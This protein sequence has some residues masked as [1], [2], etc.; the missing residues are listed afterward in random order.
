MKPG[1]LLKLHFTADV[2]TSEWQRLCGGSM[3]VLALSRENLSIDERN[4]ISVADEVRW[5]VLTPYGVGFVWNSDVDCVKRALYPSV[6][7]EER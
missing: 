7:E 4:F 6:A 2:F 3:L 5:Q 1:D